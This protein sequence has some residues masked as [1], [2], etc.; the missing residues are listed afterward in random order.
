MHLISTLLRSTEQ[1]D[2]LKNRV[3]LPIVK[4]THQKNIKLLLKTYSQFA[5]PSKSKLVKL[6]KDANLW[7]HNF[8]VTPNELYENCD[9]CKKF[10]KTLP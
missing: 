6:M 5:Y 10:S 3:N 7:D 9:I 8:D 1:T 4:T 2:F